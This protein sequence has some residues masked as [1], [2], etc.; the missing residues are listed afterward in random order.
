M[1]KAIR[2]LILSLLFFTACLPDDKPKLKNI[3]AKVNIHRFEQAF[4]SIDS[5]DFSNQ[6]AQLKNSEFEVFFI[7]NPTPS[8]W[9][10][11]RNMELMNRLYAEIKNIHPDLSEVSNHWL[12]AYKGSRYFFPDLAEELNIFTY[13]SGL[14][15]DFPIVYVDSIATFFVSLDLFMGDDHPAYRNSAEY[16]RYQNNIEFSTVL[17]IREML[18]NKVRR[19]QDDQSLLSEMIH[20]GKY[21]YALERILPYGKVDFTLNYT[22]DHLKFCKENERIMWR[23]FLE[24]DILFDQRAEF[25]RRFIDPAPFSKFYME[26][27]NLTP[28]Q[29]GQWIG[30]QI[31]RSY[32]N[33]NSEVSLSD[34][35]KNPDHRAIFAAS[36]YKP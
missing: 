13:I 27:D 19:P 2:F 33:R 15:W 6:L 29:I 7:G 4:F 34:L 30:L 26:F 28:G 8:F 32:M 21:L 12:K 5:N 24:Q 14:D 3:D 17:M 9:W 25:K 18:Y 20:H 36:G 35:L 16:L 11:Q 23:F 22:A 10:E 31:V 1:P